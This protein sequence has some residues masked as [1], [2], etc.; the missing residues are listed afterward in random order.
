M[1]RALVIGLAVLGAGAC[2][3]PGLA[4]L[5]AIKDEVCACKTTACGEAAI[6]KVP[7]HDVE[8]NHRSQRIA[9]EMLTCMA[10]IYAADTPTTDPDAEQPAPP[11]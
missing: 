2:R 1:V 8:S 7:Q 9:R 3:D 10:D 6:K 4:E 5:E 11:P